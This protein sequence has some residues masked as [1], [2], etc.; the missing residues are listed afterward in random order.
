[1]TQLQKH[2]LRTSIEVFIA[3]FVYMCVM[4]ALYYWIFGL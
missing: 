1:M 3:V 4:E 2:V